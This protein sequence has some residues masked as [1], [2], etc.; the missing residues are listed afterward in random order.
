MDLI[1]QAGSGQVAAS[2]SE[3]DVL[4]ESIRDI[5]SMIDR[6]LA[7]VQSVTS[8]K[9]Q[10]DER[11]GRKLLDSLSATVEGLEKGHLESLFSSHLQ[12]HFFSIQFIYSS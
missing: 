12:V 1:A 6:V 11:V 2:Y 9:V 7:Y 8:G 5:I 4:E 10:G 3:L